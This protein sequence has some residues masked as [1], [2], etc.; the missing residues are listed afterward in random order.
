MPERKGERKM[1]SKDATKTEVEIFGKIYPLRGHENSEYLQE[2]AAL[3]DDKMREVADQ[4]STVD[5]S[6]IAIL[7]ALNLSD[8]LYRCR[9]G[10][11]QERE[12]LE[13]KVS[14]LS[15]HLKKALEA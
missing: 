10:Q 1:S 6:R 3:V 15:G 5:T 4:V 12:K 9:R 13:E 11:D 14:E 8:E 2:L 7:A